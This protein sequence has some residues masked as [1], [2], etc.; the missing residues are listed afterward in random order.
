M[1]HTP[2]YIIKNMYFI[3]EI[4][5]KKGINLKRVYPGPFGIK[6]GYSLESR[7]WKKIKKH[8]SRATRLAENET[9]FG[10]MT[11]V[12]LYMVIMLGFP[13]RF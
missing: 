7:T 12:H 6:N 5:N 3:L 4:H 8:T 10:R 1:Y 9:S 13:N 2:E 11:R